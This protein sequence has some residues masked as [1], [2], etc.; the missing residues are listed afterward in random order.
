MTAE[1]PEAPSQ[2]EQM[3]K[4][5]VP[6]RNV[7]E[8]FSDTIQKGYQPHHNVYCELRYFLARNGPI[9]NHVKMEKKNLSDQ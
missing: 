5:L 8:S 2:T 9:P 6:V 7:T 4:P 3:N 1:E